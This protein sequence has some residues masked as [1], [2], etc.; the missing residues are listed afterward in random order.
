[1]GISPMLVFL[2]NIHKFCD[3]KKSYHLFGPLQIFKQSSLFKSYETHYFTQKKD[4]Y[5]RFAHESF[6][7]KT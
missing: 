2:L 4:S 7:Y 6:I 3:S 1:M 5:A